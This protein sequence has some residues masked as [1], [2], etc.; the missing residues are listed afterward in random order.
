MILSVSRRT[1]IPA[2]YSDWFFNRLEE[3]YVLVRNPMSIHQVSRIRL[4]P[5]VIDCIVFWS[6]NPHP[7][8][9][10][11]AELEGYNYYFQFTVNAYGSD[12]EKNIQP[13][14]ARINTF[15][16]L[17]Q[18]IGPERVIW[19]Y[20]PIIL[21][22]KYTTEYHLEHFEQIAAS[23]HGLTK[24][25]N[26]SFIDV[27]PK[28]Q[29]NLENKG[30]HEMTE[31][32]IFYIASIMAQISG[33]HG[34]RLKTCAEKIDLSQLGIE[35]AHCI[36]ENLISQLVGKP[37]KS[38][39]DKNQREECGCVSSIDIGQYNT[40]TNGCSYCYANFNPTLTERNHAEHDPQS[41]MLI[42][43]IQDGDKITD[44]EMKSLIISNEQISFLD[45]M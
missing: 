45:K 40:C 30:I 4:S 1:D 13:L 23:L 14:E 43:K 22:E 12:I 8:L 41:S 18:A 32:E 28:L 10:R 5:D 16:Q 35:H 36:D 24:Q 29:R 2:L 15:K 37:L 9:S 38:A 11:L 33:T 34:I 17:V 3:G 26:I 44:R 19:R 21:T 42:G 25:C 27:Y 39:K 6:K 20:D 7:M 31:E